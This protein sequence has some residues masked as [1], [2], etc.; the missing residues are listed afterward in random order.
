[1]MIAFQFFMVIPEPPQHDQPL[2][3]AQ[4][5][6]NLSN[7]SDGMA[8]AAEQWS[9]AEVSLKLSFHRQRPHTRRRRSFGNQSDRTRRRS[10]TASSRDRASQRHENRRQHHCVD[11][12]EEGSDQIG[13]ENLDL[14]DV[15]P[16]NQENVPIMTPFFLEPLDIYG[17]LAQPAEEDFYQDPNQ[18][19]WDELENIES[20][21]DEIADL[22]S[23]IMMG[24]PTGGRR[25][26]GTAV[27]VT[28][29]DN[30]A[31]AAD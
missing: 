5:T 1:M 20:G 21:D 16:V 7:S 10:A 22:L 13:L 9:R 28:R 18:D 26:Q 15:I 8:V 19:L 27:V 25:R 29:A 3:I 4:Q 31:P 6:A 23:A 2:Q 11:T 12:V 24:V 14:R 17:Y 30:V